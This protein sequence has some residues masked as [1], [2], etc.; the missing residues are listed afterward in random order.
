MPASTTSGPRLSSKIR[1]SMGERQRR[2]QR[3]KALDQLGRAP[4]HPGEGAVGG[5]APSF[6]L[7]WALLAFMTTV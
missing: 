2:H 5:V 4:E 6:K 1:T 7:P 3:L